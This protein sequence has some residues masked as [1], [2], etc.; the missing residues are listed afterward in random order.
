MIEGEFLK[1]T[2]FSFQFRR[3]KQRHL[4]MQDQN[5][6]TIGKKIILSHIANFL[7]Y[8]KFHS[9]S[10]INGFKVFRRKSIQFKI[11]NLQ[12][13]KNFTQYK[14]S[15]HQLGPLIVFFTL[16]LSVDLIVYCYFVNYT[17]LIS[18]ITLLLKFLPTNMR[19]KK[20]EL[21]IHIQDILLTR[22]N[23]SALIRRDMHMMKKN[24]PGM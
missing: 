7:S 11:I 18:R 10:Q 8:V 4:L 12:N 6:I 13:S 5:Q 19:K 23:M 3:S 20:N 17:D 21:S 14:I 9:I 1:I 15:C 16:S 22:Q 2:E 24:Q